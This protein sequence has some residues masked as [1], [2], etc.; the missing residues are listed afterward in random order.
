MEVLSAALGALFVQRATRDGRINLHRIMG[1]CGSFLMLGLLFSQ[2]YRLL[3]LYVPHAFAIGGTPA[4]A[5]A[6]DHKYTYFSFITLTS[7]GFG[8]VTPIHPY[9]RSL[10]T[11]EAIVGQLCIAVLIARLIGLEIEWRRERREAAPAPWASPASP[12]NAQRAAGRTALRPAGRGSSHD[13]GDRRRRPDNTVR[14][15]EG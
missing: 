8:D 3:A 13:R 12:A 1:A 5:S 15:A 14:R 9:A 11:F 10:A 6:M 2:A 4:G 7:T